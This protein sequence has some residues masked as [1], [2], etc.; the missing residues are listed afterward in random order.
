M[1][2]VLLQDIVI[3]KGTI[4]RDA[5]LKTVRAAGKFIECLVGLSDNTTGSFVYEVD[6]EVGEYFGEESEYRGGA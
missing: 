2:K 4:F 1:T 3:P 5:P 6:D